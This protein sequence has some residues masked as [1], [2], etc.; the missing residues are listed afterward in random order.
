LLFSQPALNPMPKDNKSSST[1]TAFFLNLAFTVLELAGGL[2]S[3]SI[4]IIADSLHDFADSLSLGLGWYFEHKAEKEKSNERYTYGYQRFSLLGAL[5]NALVLVLGAV[6]IF[7]ASIRRILDPQ[8]PDVPWM[9]GI[10]VLGIVLNGIGVWKLRSGKSLNKQVMT[11]HL[12][13]DSL[14]WLAVLAVSIILLFKELP[15]LDPILAIV[16]NLAVLVMISFKL[17]DVVKIFLQR[18]PEGVNVPL[19]EQKV[20]CLDGVELIR[21]FHVWGLTQKKLV[22]T[23]H[24]KTGDLTPARQKALRQ[25]ILGVFGDLDTEHV[26]IDFEEFTRYVEK[27]FENQAHRLDPLEDGVR[28]KVLRLAEDRHARTN[29]SREEALERAI[30]QAEMEQHKL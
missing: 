14:G 26:T 17:V 10:A 19:L 24:V 20:L 30:V 28:N 15:I 22:V 13:E 12:L 3:G 1:K 29:C 23:L 6:Y 16:I 8:M 9:I 18:V 7:Y 4:A 5:V 11:I 27:L 2:I 21:H 25:E